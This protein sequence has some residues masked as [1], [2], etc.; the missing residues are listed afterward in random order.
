MTQIIFKLPDKTTPGYL[1][2]VKKA[3]EFA[4]RMKA[5]TSMA[6]MDAVVEFLVDYVTEPQERSA[7][8]EA[9]MDATQEQI[10]ELL[11][12]LSGGGASTVPPASEGM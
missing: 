12:A 9:L 10:Q 5:E 6:T 4:E 11:D 8:L 3:L 2:R 7:K 1:R